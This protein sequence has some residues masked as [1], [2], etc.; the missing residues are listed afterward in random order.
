MST[1]THK[2]A[3]VYLQAVGGLL[4]LLGLVHIAATPHIPEL[5]RGSALSVYERAVG[6]TLLNHVLVGILLVPLGFTTWLAAVASERGEEWAVRVLVANT[7]VVLALPLSIAVFMHR[8]EY[9]TAPLF[10]SGVLLAVLIS[11]L[12]A[13]ATV[14]VVRGQY[15]RGQR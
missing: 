14:S 11:L 5:L 8:P 15:R 7:I 3:T 6:P 2:A 12:M 4:I 10:L 1:Q 13:A 9:Y